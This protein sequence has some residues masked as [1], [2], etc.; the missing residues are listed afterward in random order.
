MDN[1]SLLAPL[2]DQLHQEFVR[3]F[4]LALP[5]FF[6]LAIAIDWFRNPT[7]SPDFIGTLKRAFIATLLVAG[8]QEISDAILDLASAVADRI[9][10]M[11]GLDQI[12]RLAGEKCKSY[13]ASPMTLVI[14]FNDMVIAILSFLSYVVLYIARYI[15]VAVYHFM[16][17]F[18]SILSP[19]LILMSLF[20]GSQTVTLNLFRS[21]IEVASW[22]IVWAVLS[23]MI[24]T[25]SL[26]NTYAADGN[27]L[28]AI[29][30][31][32]V[33]AIAMLRTPA[34]VKSLAGAGVSAM[35]DSLGLSA[36]VAMVSVP[37]KAITTVK[38]GREVLSNTAG[39]A[40]GVGLKLWDGVRSPSPS[41]PLIPPGLPPIPESLPPSRQLPAP[42]IY[43][44][45]PD[46]YH[47]DDYFKKKP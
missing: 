38:L 3:I 35:S 32:F 18:L 44:G 33:I 7:G 30:L 21:L 10:D 47:G 43:M 8:Y 41:S 14:G 31:N 1:F 46:G 11:S 13:T 29:I 39:F 34:V 26:G 5:A 42:P 15:T 24:T 36:T 37:A 23:A 27:Y 2:A 25:L 16:W 19:L 45:A 20:R 9:S 17:V 40:K 22:K 12:L 6:A 4:Y 28:T